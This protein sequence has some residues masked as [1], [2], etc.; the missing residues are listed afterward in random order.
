MSMIRRQI[1][2]MRTSRVVGVSVTENTE[3]CKVSRGSRDALTAIV[4]S[5]ISV[6]SDESSLRLKP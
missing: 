1:A 3:N 6:L 5:L 4:C 2:D